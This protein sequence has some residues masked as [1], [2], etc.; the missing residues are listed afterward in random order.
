M[1][2]FLNLRYNIFAFSAYVPNFSIFIR[3]NQY[4]TKNDSQ[5]S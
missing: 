4:S 3:F 2:S 1:L 5:I